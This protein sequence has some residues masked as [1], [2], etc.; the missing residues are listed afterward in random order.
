MTAQDA[1]VDIALTG[2]QNLV[3]IG[4]LSRLPRRDAKR[5]AGELLER[6]ISST[7]PTAS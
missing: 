6:S 3:M 4:E 5:R 1:T 2:R 7:R